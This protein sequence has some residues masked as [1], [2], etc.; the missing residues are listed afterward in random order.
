MALEGKVAFGHMIPKYAIANLDSALLLQCIRKTRETVSM[1]ILDWK[2]IK[3]QDKPRLLA[4][5]QGAD[6][7]YQKI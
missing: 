7:P 4:L 3:S 6:L 5:L 2:G 1:A